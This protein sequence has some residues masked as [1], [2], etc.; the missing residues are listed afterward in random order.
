VLRINTADELPGNLT[1][2]VGVT[3]GASAPE[4]LVEAVIDALAPRR[5]VRE[6][7]VTDEDEYFP[8]PRNLRNLLTGVGTLA[9]FTL[10]APAAA[11]ASADDRALSASAVL[12][13]L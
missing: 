8:P 4:E 7:R 12:R 10:G 11:A 1:G 5:G 6:V 13:T 3:A 9:A 2:V